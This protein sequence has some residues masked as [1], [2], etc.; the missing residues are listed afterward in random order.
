[1]R[2]ALD[3]SPAGDLPPGHRSLASVQAGRAVA[4]LLV[5]LFHTSLAVFVLDAYW[6]TDPVRGIFDF[7]AAGV[8]WFFV[9]SGFIIFHAHAADLGRPARL[10]RYL[11]NRVLRIYPVYWL[12]LV[13]VLPV[14]LVVPSLYSGDLDLETVLSSVTLVH[15]DL[16]AP[17]LLVAW[18]LFHEI[19]FY[20][21]FALAIWHRR[22]GIVALVLWGTASVVTAFLDRGGWVDFLL[23][24][25]HLLFL[26]GVL[27]G[28][29]YLRRVPVPGALF[30][31]VGITAF[32]AMGVVE[33]ADAAFR[34]PALSGL[35]Y[36]AGATLAV[37]GLADLERRGRLRVP[38]SL[39][40]VGDA[41]YSL[42]L[43]HLP[44][45][46]VLAKLMV[47]AGLRGVVP[48]IVSYVLLVTVVVLAGVAFHLIVERPLLRRLKAR[49]RRALD[50]VPELPGLVGTRAPT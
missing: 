21:L 13:G 19:L 17:F 22:V 33:D 24:P 26:M 7:G 37:L 47:A 34:N 43:I 6:G 5:V 16:Q 50:G 25:G 11:R 8:N 30:A 23:A 45:L 10:M 46:S 42:Y 2:V 36:G 20:G 48:P 32:L 14:Y 28:W 38:A 49:G 15:V 4:A 41:S 40:L 18:T 29:A 9:L 39:C 44:L 27:A 3:T 35:V 31:V 1:M 12:V